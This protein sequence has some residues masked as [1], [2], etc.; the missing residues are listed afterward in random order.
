MNIRAKIYGGGSAADEP[1]LQVKRPK[2]AKPDTLD[3]VQVPRETF[4]KS[5][6]RGADRHRLTG[7]RARAIYE[8]NEIDVELINLSGGG[9]MVS[10]PFE[11]RLWDKVD[12]HLGN[13]GKIECAVRWIREDRVG[14]EFAHETRLDGSSEEVAS[15]LRTVIER[16]FP[17]IEFSRQE[18]RPSELRQEQQ[19]SRPHEGRIAR[20]HPLIWTGVL[21]HDYQTTKVRVR[22]ISATGAMIETQT[23]VRVGAEP[24]LELSDSTSVSAT[25]EWAVGDQVGLRFHEHLNLAALGQAKPTVA[26]SSWSPPPYLDLATKGRSKQDHWERLTIPELRHEL[27]GFLKR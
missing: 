7:E 23:A 10:G 8:G 9:A 15:V 25:V 6:S 3:S 27:E 1:L 13:H 4:R 20:R 24:L 17:N 22:N 18:E 26:K 19:A 11:C 12:L 5:N 16:T 21:Y 14:L 2:G